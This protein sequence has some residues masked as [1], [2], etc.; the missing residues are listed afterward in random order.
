[1]IRGGIG[2][3]GAEC[4]SSWTRAGECLVLAAHP[5]DETVGAAWL[6]QRVPLCTVVHL[7]DGAPIDR[8]MRERDARRS[9]QA[10]ALL[11][12]REAIDAMNVVRIPP[13]RVRCLGAVDQ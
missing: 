8:E 4:A 7:T 9:R 3:D 5:D 1:M 10:Y 6:L 11:R 12:R 13:D 2:L